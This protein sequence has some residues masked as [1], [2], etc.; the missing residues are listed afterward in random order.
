MSG[1]EPHAAARVPA[2][3]ASDFEPAAGL[4]P[5]LVD[6]AAARSADRPVELR[7]HEPARLVPAS[8]ELLDELRSRSARRIAR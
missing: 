8:G 1:R 6:P 7:A 3:G 2:R 4:R 5:V